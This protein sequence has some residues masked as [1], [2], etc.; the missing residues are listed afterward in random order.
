MLVYHGAHT[1]FKP[2]IGQSYTTDKKVAL[3]YS[4]DNGWLATARLNLNGLSVR[5]VDPYDRD[6]DTAI[7]DDGKPLLGVDVVVFDDEDPR[8]RPHKT[9]RL[10]SRK[11]LRNLRVQSI[12]WSGA[13]KAVEELKRYYG[14]E[15]DP[16][17]IADDLEMMGAPDKEIA[18]LVKQIRTAGYLDSIDLSKDDL[19]RDHK[20]VGKHVEVTPYATGPLKDL[21]GKA[22]KVKGVFLKRGQIAGYEVKI[23]GEKYRAPK[24]DFFLK[25]SFVQ[26][27]HLDSAQACHIR[28]I[29]SH[30]TKQHDFYG[31]SWHGVEAFHF[32]LAKATDRAAVESVGWYRYPSSFRPDQDGKDWRLVVPGR[33]SCTAVNCHSLLHDGVWTMNTTIYSTRQINQRRLPVIHHPD[34]WTRVLLWT[35]QVA[36]ALSQDGHYDYSEEIREINQRLRINVSLQ[37]IIRRLY[38][39]IEKAYQKVMGAPEYVPELSVGVSSWRIEPDHVGLYEPPTDEHA[40]GV[41][42]IHPKSLKDMSYLKD[43]LTHEMIHYIM[44]S[45]DVEDPHGDNFQEIARVLGLPQKY[46]D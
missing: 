35:R 46:R 13:E 37:K 30:W 21:I 29:L 23:E 1:K 45:V 2:H 26:D 28:D 32:D 12:R 11:A 38:P 8:G 42:S 10:M 24:K 27:I 41:L 34:H 7:G 39:K 43:V 9:W 40:Y 4:G 5:E 33:N 22:G 31:T 15:D 14:P 19:S 36:W 17:D 6:L 16:E 3:S 25:R 44:S 20:L 18:S